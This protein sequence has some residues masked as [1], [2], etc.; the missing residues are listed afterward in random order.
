M[1][2]RGQ[3]LYLFIRYESYNTRIQG[4]TRLNM[5]FI[6]ILPVKAEITATLGM[7]KNAK[8]AQQCWECLAMRVG[9]YQL[10]LSNTEQC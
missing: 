8:N 5:L 6:P 1:D 3:A 4:R 7:L 9:P 10:R 2:W